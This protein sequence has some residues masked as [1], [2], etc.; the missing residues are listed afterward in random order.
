MAAML[1]WNID[2]TRGSSNEIYFYSCK[3]GFDYRKERWN[4][5]FK[6]KKEIKCKE[7]A[8]LRGSNEFIYKKNLNYR[9]ILKKL[10]LHFY[11]VIPNT[12]RTNR[13]FI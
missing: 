5:E 6:R 13:I 12:I 9:K 8:I 11:D 2:K 1:L 7:M 4:D 3:K 10:H